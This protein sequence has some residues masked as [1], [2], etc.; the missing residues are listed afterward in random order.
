M[1]C[2]ACKMSRDF[3]VIPSS[4]FEK[5]QVDMQTKQ[6]TVLNESKNPITGTLKDGIYIITTSDYT[7][8]IAKS[9]YFSE[10]F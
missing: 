1:I 10:S 9:I 5:L 3:D 7:C 2:I 6:N 8:H 4:A